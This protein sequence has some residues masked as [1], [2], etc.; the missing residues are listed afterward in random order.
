MIIVV[1][2]FSLGIAAGNT[3]SVYCTH[4]KGK[5]ALFVVEILTNMSSIFSDRDDIKLGD[6]Y[7][8]YLSCSL[9]MLDFCCMI[10]GISGIMRT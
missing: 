6:V 7:R 8:T 2:P 1:T 4:Y 10:P 9:R 5:I 3:I